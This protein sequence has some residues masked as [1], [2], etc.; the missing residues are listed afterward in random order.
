MDER[1]EHGVTALLWAA[2][3]GHVEVIKV[4][5][6]LGAD[7]DA[8]NAHGATALFWAALNGHMEAIRVLVELGAN[9]EAEDRNKAVQMAAKAEE[10][11]LK[12]ILIL[13]RF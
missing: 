1:D 9:K 4:L 5:A 3:K 6:E 10:V 7:K 2:L 11:F 8:K 13:L 12:M